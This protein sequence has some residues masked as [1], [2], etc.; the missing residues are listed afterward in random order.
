[1]IS[2]VA[3]VIYAALMALVASI[4]LWW[5]PPTP[6]A[7]QVIAQA[8]FAD[9]GGARGTVRLPD[10]WP[11]GRHISHRR[12]GEYRMTF[13][14]KQLPTRALYAYIPILS[15]RAVVSLN[16]SEIADTSAR[17]LMRGMTSGTPA[18]FLLPTERLHAGDN[19]LQLR[20]HAYGTARGYLSPLYLGDV[21]QLGPHYRHMTFLLGD[22]RLM[23]AAMHLLLTLALLIAWLGRRSEP[24]FGWLLLAHVVS[25]PMFL[26]LLPDRPGPALHLLMYAVS[27]LSLPAT[28]VSP[29]VVMVVC[30]KRVPRALKR[31]IAA[32]LLAGPLIAL[33]GIEPL[34]SLL[35]R[36]T[37]PL[38]MLSALAALAICLHGARRGVRDAWLL[39]PALAG[40]LLA[41]ARDVGVWKGWIL[42]PPVPLNFYY[43]ALVQIAI[44]AILMLRLG[45]S[46][47]H[48][49]EANDDLSRRLAER[50]A[51]LERLHRRERDEEVHRARHDERQRLTVDL[52]DGLSGHLASIIALSERGKADVI[53]HAAREALD[54]L[55]LVIHS[56][57]I[58]ED[59]LLVALSGLR[60]R[61]QRQLRRLGIH[62]EWSMA[63]LPDIAGVT[64]T[65][66]LNVLR[67]VQEAVT[68]AIRHGHARRIDI[69]GGATDDGRATIMVT[70]DGLPFAPGSGGAG[71]GNM[72]RRV[73]QLH[74]EL[75]IESLPHGT[76]VHLRLPRRLPATERQR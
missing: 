60:D 48:L 46:L 28:L 32:M 65:H 58:G 66:A 25:W 51:E 42:Q 61:M 19:L 30:G 41:M 56:L 63:A 38:G 9:S 16:G 7:A 35:L 27:G 40:F 74:G 69:R 67:I 47:K 62:L 8:R 52:H 57:D 10:A 72:H 1:M 23:A 15:H 31:A 21:Q 45:Q 70:N 37:P 43:R 24:L 13:A 5:H 4:P 14:L 3:M 50:E 53:Q 44:V 17:G 36:A 6:A 68:N 76:C 29:A 2:R 54:D 49:D 34:R 12:E 20:L 73:Q 59:E 18:L 22:L 64:P 71:L 33:T 55:R 75:H 26:G 11:Q 39:L